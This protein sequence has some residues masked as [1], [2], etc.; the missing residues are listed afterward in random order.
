MTANNTKIRSHSCQGIWF[1][2]SWLNV[3]DDGVG[4][5][6]FM[7]VGYWLRCG[8]GLG[9]HGEVVGLAEPRV[10]DVGFEG[11]LT[12]GPWGGAVL[13]QF[14][15]LDWVGLGFAADCG[16]IDYDSRGDFDGGWEGHSDLD[17]CGAIAELV[18]GD[19]CGSQG[20]AGGC[21]NDTHWG[22]S[23][24]WGGPGIAARRVGIA[25]ARLLAMVWWLGSG[26]GETATKAEAT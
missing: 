4:L 20:D 16:G 3:D 21:D 12:C 26:V 6:G 5:R 1:Y 2:S 17:G 22:Y 7:V 11:W 24:H 14:W 8:L 25:A 18:V 23:H 15:L 19:G 9:L 13:V 10:G